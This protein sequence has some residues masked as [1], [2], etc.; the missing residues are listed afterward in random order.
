MALK[1]GGAMVE[2]YSL[3][4]VLKSMYEIEGFRSAKILFENAKNRYKIP[5]IVNQ[6][7][8]ILLNGRTLS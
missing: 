4:P 6:Q 3:L 1:N 5:N 2:F 7:S 8:S